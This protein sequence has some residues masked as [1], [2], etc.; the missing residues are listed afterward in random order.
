MEKWVSTLLNLAILAVWIAGFL[1]VMFRPDRVAELAL[2]PFR[3]RLFPLAMQIA[4]SIRQQPEAWTYEPVRLRAT[5]I[6]SGLVIY[7]GG[8]EASGV[9]F[10]T[11]SGEWK[12]DIVSRRIVRDALDHL[13]RNEVS[14]LTRSY[15]APQG[16]E[17]QLRLTHEGRAPL[18]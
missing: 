17:A 7:T 6:P 2:R 14:D 5:H 11:R 10:Q 9:R 16:R 8:A 4:E 13:V 15:M 18:S 12:P 1:F 3:A